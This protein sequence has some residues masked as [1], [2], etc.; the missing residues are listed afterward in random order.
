MTNFR[1]KINIF[2]FKD[3]DVILFQRIWLMIIRRHHV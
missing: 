3:C 2:L 1:D